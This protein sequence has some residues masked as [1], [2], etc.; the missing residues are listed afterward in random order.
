MSS[1]RQEKIVGK[2]VAGLLVCLI[3]CSI[4]GGIGAASG[5]KIKIAADN[6]EVIELNTVVLT[7]TGTA[8][9]KIH[10]ESIFGT[11]GIEFIEGKK[12][13]PEAYNFKKKRSQESRWHQVHICI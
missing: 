12:E 10:V 4:F 5:G 1:T 7:V 9:H 11:E 2:I 13:L 8:E 3:L 6:T